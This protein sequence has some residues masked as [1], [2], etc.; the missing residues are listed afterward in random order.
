MNS[1]ILHN[2]SFALNQ[3]FCVNSPEEEISETS[4]KLNISFASRSTRKSTPKMT[5]EEK[6]IAYY[7]GLEKFKAKKLNKKI[8]GED[9]S[10]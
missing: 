6:E 10:K 4:S 7:Q 1:S 5:T 8:M 2:T 3:S 9:F